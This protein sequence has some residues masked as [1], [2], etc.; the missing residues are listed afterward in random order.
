R[1]PA[2][3]RRRPAIRWQPARRKVFL[4]ELI[5]TFPF[6]EIRCTVPALGKRRID[7]RLAVPETAATA[8]NDRERSI[9]FRRP[10]WRRPDSHARS[11]RSEILQWRL[12]CAG[13][14]EI[15]FSAL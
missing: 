10:T 3:I 11:G 14:S 1:L 4:P 15:D 2:L 7:I 12:M 5:G 9:K 6:G 13:A 8:T